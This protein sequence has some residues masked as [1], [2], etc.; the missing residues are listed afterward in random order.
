MLDRLAREGV[1]A[2]ASEMV[3]KLLGAT[4]TGARPQLVAE[5]R[6]MIERQT[7]AGV[8]G[9]LR[10]IMSRPDSS[11]LLGTIDVPTLVVVG[12]EDVMTPPAEAERLREGIAGSRMVRITKAGHLSNLEQP[13]P[14]NETLT[15]FLNSEF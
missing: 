15:T 4:T 2:V 5:V 6:S 9:A 13:R 11:A 10:A 3:P 14:F 1:T 8:E 7:A 12:E